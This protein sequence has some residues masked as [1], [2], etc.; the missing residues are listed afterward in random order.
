MSSS[1]DPDKETECTR[2]RTL[3][4]IGNSGHGLPLRV[5]LWLGIPC[6][7]TGATE[8]RS[9]ELSELKREG[10]AGRWVQVSNSR[11]RSYGEFI[12]VLREGAGS[13]PQLQSGRSRRVNPK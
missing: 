7:G 11:D 8:T 4:S 6:S 9:K 12:N 3:V 10:G 2:R 5:C 1:L 13:Q